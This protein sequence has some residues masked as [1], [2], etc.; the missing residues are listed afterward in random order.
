MGG[1]CRPP[2]GSWRPFFVQDMKIQSSRTVSRNRLPPDP[3]RRYICKGTC[4]NGYSCFDFLMFTDFTAADRWTKKQVHCL[5]QALI[6]A[7]A[8]RHAPRNKETITLPLQS[9]NR[10]H[11][12][13]P[14]RCSGHQVPG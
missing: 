7:I 2:A 5:Y 13:P 9:P 1:I 6:V 4:F 8:T 10:S 12:P 3:A 14:R 11:P